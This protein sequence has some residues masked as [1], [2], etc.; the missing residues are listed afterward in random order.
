M[1]AT[2]A[3]VSPHKPVSGKIMQPAFSRRDCPRRL[4]VATNSHQF[5]AF[6]MESK[7]NV[8]SQDETFSFEIPS[9]LAASNA[10]A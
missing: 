10:S 1:K 2:H 5:I 9:F 4:T 8:N 6:L 7:L 3:S